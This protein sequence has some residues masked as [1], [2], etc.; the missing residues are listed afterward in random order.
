MEIIFQE[1]DGKG[2]SP[3][4]VSRGGGG[5]GE[6][7]VLPYISHIDVPPHRVWFLRRFGLNTDIHFIHLVW[8]R[9]WFLSE[10]RSVLTYL[11]FQF[12]MSKKERE[13]C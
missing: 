8:N 3:L 2:K 12:Q 13:I 11:L 10:L 7:G 9:V 4:F 1:K 5:G 6:V